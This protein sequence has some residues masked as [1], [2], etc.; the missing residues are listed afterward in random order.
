MVFKLLRRGLD[1]FSDRL[2]VSVWVFRATVRGSTRATSP[3]KCSVDLRRGFQGGF[4]V[5]F[6]TMYPAVSTVVARHHW[7]KTDSR[8]G[9][10]RLRNF[11]FARLC[12]SVAIG[13]TPIRRIV[14]AVELN[15]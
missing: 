4:R 3:R 1:P 11:N 12:R 10:P 5:G 7:K 13:F 6:Q 8:Q 14:R 15:G 9:E 2:S